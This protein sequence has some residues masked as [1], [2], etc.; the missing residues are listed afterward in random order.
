MQ[1]CNTIG[2]DRNIIYRIIGKCS[3]C[4]IA[5]QS[6][7]YSSNPYI[8]CHIFG[9]TPNILKRIFQSIG[10]IIMKAGELPF[11]IVENTSSIS[12]KP[13]PILGIKVG[14]NYQVFCN[15]AILIIILG[16]LASC[17]VYPGNPVSVRSQPDIPY[18]VF[19][20]AADVILSCSILPFEKS[21]V[22]TCIC[23]PSFTCTYPHDILSIM[24]ETIY[25][26]GRNREAV[27]FFIHYFCALITVYIINSNSRII[28]TNPYIS[29]SIIYHSCHKIISTVVIVH[30][31]LQHFG[32]RIIVLQ[33]IF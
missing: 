9:D 17:C 12:T 21:I 11:F 20:Y 18:P 14:T 16:K 29:F 2:A 24:V 13:Y 8:P 31:F 6:L 27:V 3:I 22:E 19:Q 28:G 30:K 4:F 23:N 7:H 10:I 33:C 5:I 26:I 15:G 25:M 1:V 32:L